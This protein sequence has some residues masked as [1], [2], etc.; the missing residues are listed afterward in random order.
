MTAEYA[1]PRRFA[2]NDLTADVPAGQ[3]PVRVQVPGRAFVCLQIDKSLS[4]RDRS[5]MRAAGRPYRFDDMN[6]TAS[7]ATMMTPKDS[8]PAKASIQSSPHLGSCRCRPFADHPPPARRAT[9][10]DASRSPGDIRIRLIVRHRLG[11]RPRSGSDVRD[12][13]SDKG[14]ACPVSSRWLWL[15]SID[16]HCQLFV[17]GPKTIEASVL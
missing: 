4:R 6:L 12:V 9:C 10:F 16:Q 7:P 2:P 1:S 11:A 13:E 15:S 8:N 17:L 14:D 5:R 3:R